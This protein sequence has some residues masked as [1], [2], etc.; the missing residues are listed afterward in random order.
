MIKLSR[1]GVAAAAALL[2][3]GTGSL[4]WAATSA[5]AAAASPAART[6]PTP[7]GYIPRC[8][9]GDLAVWVN[10][11][12]AN[13]AAGTIYYH[14]DYTNTSSTTC[15][16]YSWPG[17]SAV[18]GA[19]QQLGAAAQHIGGA[20]A[21]YVNIPAGGTAHSV[22]GYVDVQVT[23]VCKPATAMFLRVYPPD[24]TGARYAFFPQRVCTTKTTDLVVGRVQPGA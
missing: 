5:S 9:P 4:T 19:K 6:A 3:A 10:A 2:A 1:R 14:L 12:T 21:S 16:L 22:L 17:V 7:S 20:S 18:N 15:H 8:T 13:G 24:D 23:P 11:D